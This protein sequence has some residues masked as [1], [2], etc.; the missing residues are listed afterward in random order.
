MNFQEY[1][2]QANLHFL[3]NPRMRYGQALMNFLWRVDGETY[4]L[5]P[6]ELDPYY[7]DAKTEDF[8]AYLQ[9]VWPENG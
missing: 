6:N 8:L 2:R 4:S 1:H 7:D 9:G 3:D 5:V